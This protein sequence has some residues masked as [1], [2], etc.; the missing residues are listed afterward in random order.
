MKVSKIKSKVYNLVK[1]IPKGKV[2]TYKIVSL[3]TG[4][5]PRLIGR[6]LSQNSNLN[7]IPCFRVV[8][9]NGFIGGYVKGIK[10]KK[11]KLKIEGVKIKN[12][13]IVDFKEKIFNF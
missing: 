12:F 1:K 11:R 4:L 10:E 9:S 8:C 13:K 7:E 3:K 2:S 6:I 5:N